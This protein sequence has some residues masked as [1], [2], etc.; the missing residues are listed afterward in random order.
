M[1]FFLSGLFHSACLPG[2]SPCLHG[3]MSPCLQ[4]GLSRGLFRVLEHVSEKN[5]RNSSGFSK[6]RQSFIRKWKAKVD[7]LRA[8]GSLSREPW[9]IKDDFLLGFIGR[10]WIIQRD[11]ISLRLGNIEQ[12]CVFPLEGLVWHVGFSISGC[13]VVSQMIGPEGHG[14]IKC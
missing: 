4:A 12:Y 6:E 1:S 2:L 8:E 9:G 11:W 3:D 10:I 7:A 14:P 5:L 13:W